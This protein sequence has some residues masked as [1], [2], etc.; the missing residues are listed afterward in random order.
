MIVTIFEK[1]VDCNMQPVVSR[2]SGVNRIQCI[3]GTLE[4]EVFR[5]FKSDFRPY[6]YKD[7]FY[8]TIEN[9][10]KDLD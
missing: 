3:D 6:K 10:P 8:Y 4:F 7:Y 5:P 9:D 1:R 2:F